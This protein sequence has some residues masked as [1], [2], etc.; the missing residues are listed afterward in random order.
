MKKLF[1]KCQGTGRKL[2]HINSLCTKLDSIRSIETEADPG[3]V[4]SS[5]SNFQLKFFHTKEKHFLVVFDRPSL[6]QLFCAPFYFIH[7]C[8]YMT[9]LMRSHYP[10]SLVKLFYL[11]PKI[12]SL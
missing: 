1:N 5:C 8:M 7:V 4:N 10:A 2:S 6:A 11:L 9:N 3:I 12:I